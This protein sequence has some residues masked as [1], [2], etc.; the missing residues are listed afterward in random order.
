M[1]CCI[2]VPSHYLNQC[3]LMISEALWH[4]PD[5]NFTEDNWDIHNWNRV[6][7]LLISDCSRSP[8]GQWVKWW[9]NAITYH[10]FDYIE[11][12]LIDLKTSIDIRAP[13]VI[14]L[15]ITYRMQWLICIRCWQYLISMKWLMYGISASLGCFFPQTFFFKKQTGL[16]T[17]R[18]MF[19]NDTYCVSLT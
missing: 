1:A 12:L 18:L 4:P 13:L 11:V 6:W 5:S 10:N 16:V 9:H 2:T 8:R 3:W 7:N 15:H 19:L 17:F 14:T